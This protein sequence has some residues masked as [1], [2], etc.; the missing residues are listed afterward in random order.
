MF[1]FEIPL[2][3]KYGQNELAILSSTVGLKV[4][5]I[6]I[7]DVTLVNICGYPRKPLKLTNLC[8]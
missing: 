5:M 6:L 2:P 8:I 1:E 7:F 3:L 4:H